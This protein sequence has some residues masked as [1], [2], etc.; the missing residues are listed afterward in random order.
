MLTGSEIVPVTRPTCFYFPSGFYLL[1]LRVIFFE[2]PCLFIHLS[3]TICSGGYVKLLHT[4]DLHLGHRLFDRSRLEEQRLFLDW[5]VDLTRSEAPDLLIIAGDVFD[6]GTP[7]NAALELY[8]DFLYRVSRTSCRGTVVTGGNHDSVSTLNAPRQLLNRFRV[9]VVGGAMSSEE[10]LFVLKDEKDRPLACIGCV[11]FLRERDIRQPRAGESL[12]ERDAAITAGLREHY[13]AVSQAASVFS[14]VPFIVT[15]HLLAAGGGTSS[16]ERDLYVGSLGQ[17]DASVFPS[18]ADYCA[19]GHL[20]RGRIVGGHEHI[21]YSGSPLALDFGDETQKS[22]VLAEF[23]ARRLSSL[24]QFPVPVFRRLVSL[25][26]SL[27]EILWNLDDV[28]GHGEELT[29]WLDISVTDQVP[30]AQERIDEASATLSLEILRV[31]YT[32]NGVGEDSWEG[33]DL[34]LNE[35]SPLEVFKRRCESRGEEA[36]DE[37]LRAYQELLVIA[38]EN[39][40]AGM[41]EEEL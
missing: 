41:E 27:P 8:Y 7:P 26:G 14:Q 34:H 39:L 24:E 3:S 16:S 38:E 11:P 31:R 9:H 21:R 40:T 30:E 22:V 19:L 28:A 20:H 15:G 29:P 35:L 10:E 33:A 18:S 25:S 6:T 36:D 12:D 32:R 23:D 2:T 17:V 4:S 5:L 1:S 37:L 13:R